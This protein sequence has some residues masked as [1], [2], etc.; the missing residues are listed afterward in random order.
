MVVGALAGGVSDGGYGSRNH[1]IDAIYCSVTFC[2]V[3]LLIGLRR[4]R[5]PIPLRDFGY[6]PVGVRGQKGVLLI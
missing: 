6:Q 4:G 5:Q 1:G 2:W 3:A